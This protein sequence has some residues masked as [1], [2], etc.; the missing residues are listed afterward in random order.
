MLWMFFLV[1]TVVASTLIILKAIVTWSINREE[2]K[3]LDLET[4]IQTPVE[5]DD[6][7]S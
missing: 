2:R 3:I 1:I 7:D 6:R 4:S 5:P